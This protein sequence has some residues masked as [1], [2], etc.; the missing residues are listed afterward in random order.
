M[1]SRTTSVA[2]AAIC[3]MI[4]ATNLSAAPK[5]SVAEDLFNFGYAPQNAK[6]GHDFWLNSVGDDTLRILKVIPGCGCTKAPLEKDAVAAGDSTRME[7]LFSTG[8]YRN[9][10]EKH[11][12]VQTNEGDGNRVLTIVA[13]VVDRPDSTYPVIITPYKIDLS[14]FGEKRVDKATFSITN[15]SEDDLNLS[16]VWAKSDYFTV[17]LPGSIGPGETAQGTIALTEKGKTISFE[18]SFTLQLSDMAGSRF[19][20]P[21]KRSMREAAVKVAPARG[22]AGGDK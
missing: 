11:P 19:T 16:M 21:V 15:V 10:V 20:V 22:Y 4:A 17:T 18:N 12:R 2:A 13:T 1:F 7:I 6:I 8:H 9:R 3:L 14:Q 5:L